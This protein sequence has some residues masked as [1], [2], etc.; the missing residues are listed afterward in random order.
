MTQ[1]V[2][3]FEGVAKFNSRAYVSENGSDVYF[4]E[5]RSLPKCD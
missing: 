1:Q 2:A 5:E 4:V 3:R